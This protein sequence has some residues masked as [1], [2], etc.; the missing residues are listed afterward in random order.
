LRKLIIAASLCALAA[1][2]AAQPPRRPVPA[3]DDVARR[4][5]PPAEIEAM[6]DAIGRTA[7]ALMG[8]DVG[9]VHDALDPYRRPGRRETLGDIASRDD[10]YA[11]ERIHRTIGSTS[12]GM[13]AAMNELAIMTPLLRRSLLDAA[14]RIE[15]AA[16][17]GAYPRQ[18]GYH[19]DSDRDRDY[20]RD[21]D[22]DDDRDRDGDRGD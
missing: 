11:R 4:L 6:G 17:A 22:R 12:A 3:D 16:R 10:P 8:V 15:S 5:P 13:A 18:R 21:Y 9:P 2:V 14:I 19:R 20:D 7:D 1:P